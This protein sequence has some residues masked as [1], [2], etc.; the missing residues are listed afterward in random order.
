MGLS[1]MPIDRCGPR[2]RQW[3]QI[4][5]ARGFNL[6]SRRAFVNQRLLL[7]QYQLD[8]RTT[9]DPPRPP[10]ESASPLVNQHVIPQRDLLADSTLV[11]AGL[12]ARS[13]Q[14]LVFRYSIC[15]VPLNQLHR[16]LA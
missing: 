12:A 11:M 16:I 7:P 10:D 1:G 2:A 8:G 5:R 15:C 13:F 14:A 4:Q 6:L 3:Q 9:E